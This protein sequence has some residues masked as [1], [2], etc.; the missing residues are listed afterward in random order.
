MFT[1]TS[2]FEDFT[3][4]GSSYTEFF[5]NMT[6]MI[7]YSQ[8]STELLSIL[9]NS[10]IDLL[11]TALN[12]Q[13]DTPSGIKFN[14]AL[15]KRIKATKTPSELLELLRQSSCYNWLDYRILEVLAVG[16]RKQSAQM[17]VKAYESF[18]FSKTLDQILSEFPEPN[19]VKEEFIT[20]V[21]AKINITNI[22]KITVGVLFDHVNALNTVILNLGKN[23]V[24]IK[25]IKKGCLAVFWSIPIRYSF[26]AYKIALYNRHKACTVHML[27]LT[28][29]TH[30]IIYDPWL[31]DL[32]EHKRKEVFHEHE[33]D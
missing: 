2:N 32:E 11:K 26:N 27:S 25:D 24:D 31:F 33:G 7:A 23:V 29:G 5:T 22:D 4:D 13:A 15:Q 6:I 30:P 8:L 19:E 12:H 18:L 21:G 17:L 28:I 16:T 9:K 1:D 10:N 20:K 3:D 14:E